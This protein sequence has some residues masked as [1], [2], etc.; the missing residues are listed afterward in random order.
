MEQSYS[1]MILQDSVL[2]HLLNL[3]KIVKKGFTAICLIAIFY[4]PSSTS[5][6]CN[7]KCLLRKMNSDTS[8][9]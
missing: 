3:D 6:S 7:Q 5:T 9:A 8:S 2:N 1:L 4:M